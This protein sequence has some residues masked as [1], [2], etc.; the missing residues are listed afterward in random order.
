[1]ITDIAHKVL[2]GAPVSI[3]T[4]LVNV[5]WQGDANRLALR[6]LTRA[7]VPTMVPA[8]DV[9]VALNVTGSIV[10]V[11]EIAERVG[12]IAGVQPL[13]SGT[14]SDDALIAN[15]ERLA[16]ALPYEAMPLETL[17]AWAVAWI[18]SGGRLLNKPTKFEVRDGR[19]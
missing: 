9:N 2:H 16:E 13:F 17:C 12:R 11:R 6:A 4:P 7:T 18:R 8:A 10:S 14:P 15:V 19:Y 5:I 1:M 3:D